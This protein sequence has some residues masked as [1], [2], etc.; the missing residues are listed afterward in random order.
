MYVRVIVDMKRLQDELP[1][2]LGPGL[3]N[4]KRIFEALSV[5]A[6]ARIDLMSIYS[7]LAECRLPVPYSRLAEQAATLAVE[8]EPFCSVDFL[9]CLVAL[10]RRELAVLRGLLQGQTAIERL[11]LKESVTHLMSAKSE[12]AGMDDQ[13]ASRAS[14]SAS[15]WGKCRLVG[16]DCRWIRGSGVGIRRARRRN[17]DLMAQ[18][19]LS[20]CGSS[21][22]R[23]LPSWGSTSTRH[24]PP[25]SVWCRPRGRGGADGGRRTAR[26][27]L[28]WKLWSR[29]FVGWR[30]RRCLFCSI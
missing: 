14:A 29:L 21:I 22:R 10:Y 2:S 12:L 20:G 13:S 3:Q 25:W 15:V 11:D 28:S 19:C 17:K 24:S 4:L 30:V 8:M 9:D 1:S 7:T 18:L 23:S 6:Q 27:P 26:S 16:A 5:F